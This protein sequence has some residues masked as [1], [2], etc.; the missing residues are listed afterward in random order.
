LHSTT[1]GHA[2]TYW[3][4]RDALGPRQQ[5]QPTL[6]YILAL[7]RRYLQQVCDVAGVAPAPGT[8]ADLIV[9]ATFEADPGPFLALSQ[10]DTCPDN[11]MREGEWMRFLDF[12]GGRF[13]NALSDGARARSNFPT[14]WLVNRLPDAI[15]RRTEAVYQAELSKGCPQAADDTLFYREVVKACACWALAAFEFYSEVGIWEED[16]QWG[17]A[18]TRQRAITRFQLLAQAT[19]EFGFLEAL[20]AT[21]QHL[22]LALQKLWPEVAPMPYYPPFR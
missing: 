13:R 21:A 17:A 16:H 12:E 7:L 6:E 22:A 11:C 8:D 5:P 3:R 4:L 1:H 14:C 19:A 10:S 9:G 18:T 2:E 20:G 15:I